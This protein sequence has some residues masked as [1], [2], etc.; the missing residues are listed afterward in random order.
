MLLLQ[1][2]GQFHYLVP[3]EGSTSYAQRPVWQGSVHVTNPNDSPA[4]LSLGDVFPYEGTILCPSQEPFVRGPHQ[5]VFLVPTRYCG[6]ESLRAFTFS[7]DQ[8]VVATL[9]FKGY[10]SCGSTAC[11]PFT[12]DPRWRHFPISS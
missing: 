8:P 9:E 10:P 5:S 4:A 11:L 6:N 3:V 1:T 7:T 2:A 12:N